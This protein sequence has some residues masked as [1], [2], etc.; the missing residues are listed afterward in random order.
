MTPYRFMVKF[1]CFEG[2]CCEDEGSMVLQNAVPYFSTAW[3]H[4]LEDLDVNF[5]HR[6]KYKSLILVSR[7]TV[8]KTDECFHAKKKAVC[9][10]FF[11]L[12]SE[13]PDSAL[14]IITSTC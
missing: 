8:K 14:F 13:L 12:Y 10:R 5:H 4:N 3:R 2:P 11:G 7:G 1:L 9:D 6:R